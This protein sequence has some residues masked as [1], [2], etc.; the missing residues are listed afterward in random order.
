VTRA[1]PRTG[2]HRPTQ[3]RAVLRLVRGNKRPAS[4]PDAIAGRM[5]GG[6][7]ISRGFMDFKPGRCSVRPSASHMLRGPFD[8]RK[9]AYGLVH[10]HKGG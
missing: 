7:R 8:L 10:A 6:A 1:N 5:S 2:P 9:A 4:P 3:A